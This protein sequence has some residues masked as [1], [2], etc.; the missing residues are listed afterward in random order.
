MDLITLFLCLLLLTMA[1]FLVY[2]LHFL[3]WVL[4]FWHFAY[5]KSLRPGI[6]L[7]SIRENFHLCLS[8]AGCLGIPLTHD[9]LNLKVW[10]NNINN[11]ISVLKPLWRASFWLEFGKGQT[12]FFLLEWILRAYIGKY[13]TVFL[14]METLI[15]SVKDV[16]FG[17]PSSVQS[18]WFAVKVMTLAY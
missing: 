17:C 4:T 8:S 16:A 7:P 6:R 10:G 9:F 13:P 11:L 3:L 1:Y 12:S 5:G 14:F 15:H 2:F 18:L